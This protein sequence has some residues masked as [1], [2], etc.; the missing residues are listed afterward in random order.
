MSSQDMV[1]DAERSS[2]SGIRS[3]SQARRPRSFWEALYE[4]WRVSGQSKSAFCAARGV[5]RYSFD[6]WCQKFARERPA[7]EAVAVARSAFVAVKPAAAPPCS[8]VTLCIGDVS[9]RFEGTMTPDA[10]A[11]W[12]RTLRAGAC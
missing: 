1:E 7:S 6:N 5:N 12:A 8:G 10:L 2:A 11:A 4:Q 9:V 3:P